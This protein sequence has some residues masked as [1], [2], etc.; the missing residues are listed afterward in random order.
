MYQI[1][2]NTKKD[3]PDDQA[4]DDM[5]LYN[6]FIQVTADFTY[7]LLEY[8]YNK[9]LIFFRISQIF[10]KLLIEYIQ[11]DA[12]RT[13]SHLKEYAEKMQHYYGEE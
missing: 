1:E 10:T 13:H 9:D 4:S 7:E 5:A 12:K 2:I 8:A 3:T 11:I 6:A